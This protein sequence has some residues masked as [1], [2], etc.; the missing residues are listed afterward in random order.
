MGKPGVT[1]P[2]VVRKALEQTDLDSAVSVVLDAKL[3]G[4]HNFML[5]GPDGEAVN[6][7]AMPGERV[8]TR[9]SDRPITHANHCLNESTAR[10]EGKRDPV[11]VEDSDLRQKVGA[12]LA[13]DAEALFAD[14]RISRRAEG[15]H[16][17][18]SCGAV[19]IEPQERK[20]RATWGVPGDH[21]WET[22]QF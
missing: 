2:F 10:E 5:M 7:E 4:G 17:V 11:H 16:D 19:W 13:H 6:I 21:P 18:G 8:V 12:E 3:A 9:S 20:M 1:W 15:T 14:P 22:F